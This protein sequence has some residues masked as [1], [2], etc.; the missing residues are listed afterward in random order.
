[1]KVIDNAVDLNS[2]PG[3]ICVAI[4]VFDGVHLGHQS[5]IGKACGIARALGAQSAVV[6][7]DRHP[8]TIVAPSHV[9]AQIYPLTKKL[10]VLASLG[11]DMACV[12]RF[13][14]AFSEISGEDFI[15]GLARDA[16]GLLAVSVGET[17]QFGCKRTGN[18]ELLRK[19]G[20]ELGFEVHAI[21]DISLNGQPISSTRI[22]EAVRAGDFDQA[23]LFLG[24]PYSL[25]GAIVAGAR[26][27]QK[28]G[29]PT[30]NL[31]VAGSLV[32]PAGVYAAQAL[33]DKKK[34]R[35]A[36]NIGNRPTIYSAESGLTVEAH[37]LDFNQNI[38][39]EELELVFVKKLRDERKFPHAAALQQQITADVAAVRSM[40]GLV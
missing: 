11:V 22:R 26:M 5:V 36:V 37:L 28:L 2:G 16:R 23:G 40:A 19:L 32:P 20:S 8:N 34:Y 18:V 4:G 38:Y 17:F 35:A 33:F 14:K 15:R 10:E 39:G 27:G 3:G 7:F 29:F 21:P 9:P 13:D 30:A 24:R 25:S 1:M 31:N 6:T 12:L